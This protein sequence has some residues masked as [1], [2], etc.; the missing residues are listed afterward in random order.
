MHE[1]HLDMVLILVGQIG[2]HVGSNLCHSICLRHL[3]K[4]K[5][6]TNRIFSPKRPT[7][8]CACE[9]CAELPSNISTMHLFNPSARLFNSLIHLFRLWYKAGVINYNNNYCIVVIYTANRNRIN[10]LL[11][12]VIMF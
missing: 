10:T 7:V 6:V 1:K 4:S 9:T 5:A 2:A 11:L 8:P 12:Y 3:L